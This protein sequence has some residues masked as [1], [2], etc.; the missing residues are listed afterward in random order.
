M[1]SAK[2]IERLRDSDFSFFL[3]ELVYRKAHFQPERSGHYP[4]FPLEVQFLFGV[5][6]QNP[7]TFDLKLRALDYT[8]YFNDQEVGKGRMD[9]EILIAKSAATLVQVPLQADFRILGNPLKE[10]LAGKDLRYKIEGAAIVKATLGQRHDPVFEERGDKNKEIG[11]KGQKG[12]RGKRGKR[13]DQPFPFR[14][15]PFSSSLTLKQGVDEVAGVELPQ[16]VDFFP[17]ADVADRDFQLVG[18]RH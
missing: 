7:N 8:V 12:K 10:I 3:L 6:V 2:I 13:S 15:F 17:D 16:V 18:N 4:L 1:K 14:P 9:Q 5:E 11:G